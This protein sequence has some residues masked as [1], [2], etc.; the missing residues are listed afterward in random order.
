M[1]KFN[2]KAALAYA[3]MVNKFIVEEDFDVFELYF[4]KFMEA[5]ENVA[6]D[7]TCD[8][9]INPTQKL[10]FDDTP[11]SK[12]R[13]P[14]PGEIYSDVCGNRYFVVDV[15]KFSSDGAPIEE[16]FV[17]LGRLQK[18]YIHSIE[19]VLIMTLKEFA[20]PA[21]AFTKEE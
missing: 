12:L 13:E 19:S 7:G 5:Y 17:V 16:P 10:A 20:A 14:K 1:K 11:V 18:P 4:D 2:H 6:D 9:F 3:D 8:E 15:K 21:L